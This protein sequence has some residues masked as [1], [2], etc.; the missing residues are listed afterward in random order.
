MREAW[1][2]LKLK[3]R[4]E[5]RLLALGHLRRCPHG[6]VGVTS[7]DDAERIAS[8]WSIAVGRDGRAMAIAAIR[9]VLRRHRDCVG[10]PAPDDACS[11]GT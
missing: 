6:V 8:G 10:C 1:L 3:Q 11:D 2:W 4:T 5:R 7:P 9:H